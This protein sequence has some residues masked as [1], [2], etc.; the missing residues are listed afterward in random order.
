MNELPVKK[1][2]LEQEIDL[3]PN[4]D[5]IRDLLGKMDLKILE[6]LKEKPSAENVKKAALILARKKEIEE[7]VQLSNMA[8]G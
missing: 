5:R 6:I 1:L 2:T 4:S 7:R 8:S 3:N